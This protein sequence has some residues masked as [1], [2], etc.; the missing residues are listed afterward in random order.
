MS[1]RGSPPTP[2]VWPPASAYERLSLERE[3]A[4]KMTSAAEAELVR[5][6]AEASRQ[7]LY[8]ERISEPNLADDST[9]PKRIPSVV[10]VFAANLLL[11]LV[12]WLILS[13]VREHAQ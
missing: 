7:L 2:E 3:F 8:L 11:V 10:T 5:S 6:R 4:N 9:Q 1:A 12:G 13:G